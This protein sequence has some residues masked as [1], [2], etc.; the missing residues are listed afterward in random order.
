MAAKI[1]DNFLSRTAPHHR[2][3]LNKLLA[4][5]PQGVAGSTDIVSAST[6][7]DTVKCIDTENP[8]CRQ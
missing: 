7:A 1:A 3:T 4:Q 2:D 6:W 5:H 8:W